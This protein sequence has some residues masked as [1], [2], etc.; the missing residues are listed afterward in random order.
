[1]FL[2][3]ASEMSARRDS[4]HNVTVLPEMIVPTKKLASLTYVCVL[5][6][7]VC[8]CVCVCV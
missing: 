8:V 3:E 6:V 5:P 2:C 4:L 7:C 1:M